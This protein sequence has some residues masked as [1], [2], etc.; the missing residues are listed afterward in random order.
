MCLWISVCKTVWGV[1]KNGVEDEWSPWIE[2]SVSFVRRYPKTIDREGKQSFWWE[3][4]L[5]KVNTHL[6]MKTENGD[7]VNFYADLKQS[8][9]RT[10]IILGYEKNSSAS[11]NRER[12]SFFVNRSSNQKS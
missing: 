7:V 11:E 12:R 10:M 4:G 5:L 6:D 1:L 8:G 2:L 3:H 9:V